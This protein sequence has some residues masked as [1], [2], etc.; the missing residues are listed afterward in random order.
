[1]WASDWIKMSSHQEPLPTEKWQAAQMMFSTRFLLS[2]AHMTGNMVTTGSRRATWEQRDTV[3]DPCGPLEVFK[4][5]VREEKC[6]TR[7]G[8]SLLQDT[9]KLTLLALSLQLSF[10]RVNSW[11]TSGRDYPLTVTPSSRHLSRA[12][13][14]AEGAQRQL[15]FLSVK[16]DS[17]VTLLSSGHSSPLDNRC[18]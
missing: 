3:A 2:G 9:G 10:T 17:T 16:G 12:K 15:R 6:L 11:C 8:S 5:L 4:W 18:F 7:S 13:D 1:M 14:R